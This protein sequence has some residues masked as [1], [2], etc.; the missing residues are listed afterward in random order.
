MKGTPMLFRHAKKLH[1]RDEVELKTDQGTWVVGW[2]VG[3]VTIDGKVAMV[4]IQVHEGE[5]LRGVN[6]LRI[7]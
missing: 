4:D 3:E 1:D 2:V 7:R 5:F 6:H